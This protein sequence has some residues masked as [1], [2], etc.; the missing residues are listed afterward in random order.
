MTETNEYYCNSKGKKIQCFDWSWICP[1][2]EMTC[3]DK[4]HTFYLPKGV[5][6]LSHKQNTDDMDNMF[7]TVNRKSNE[8]KQKRTALLLSE[9]QLLDID[10][11]DENE[12]TR[13]TLH[14]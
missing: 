2:K 13:I 6:T 1:N 9:K 12:E 7:V 5:F 10:D 14:L 11:R 3:W 4:F 8:Y